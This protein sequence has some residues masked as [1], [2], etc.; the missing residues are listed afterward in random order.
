MYGKIN[1]ISSFFNKWCSAFFLLFI[2]TL[3]SCITKRGSDSVVVYSTAV[4]D[5][6]E[7]YTTLPQ[8]YNA[9]ET[10][11]I[12]FYMD[13]NLKTGK[14]VRKQISL[15]ENL[16]QLKKVIFIGVGHM[17]N[18]RELRRRDFIPPIV[19]K[20]DTVISNKKNFGHADKFYDFLA[21]EL[22]PLVQGKYK[23]NK[24]YS[25]IGHS[26][27]GLFS[28][29]CLLKK[30]DLF[31]NYIALS[32]SLWVNYRNYFDQEEWFN[33]QQ[34]KMEG[35]LY[36]SCGS[37]E[38]INKVLNSSRNMRNVLTTRNYPDLKYTYQEHKGKN[39]NGVLGVSLEYV[40]KN[41]PL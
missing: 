1:F 2:I 18:Y 5:S 15:P 19:K 6:F 16:A 4:Q 25:I 37:L 41:A 20:D 35:Y 9:N 3:Y 32:P 24:R 26:F 38:W 14:E 8:G 12:V 11:S 36:H 33:N 21:T 40:I 17:G 29:Y 23:T 13:A 28:F 22:I 27:S 34:K 39:H 31:T 10:Y 30:P 7:I